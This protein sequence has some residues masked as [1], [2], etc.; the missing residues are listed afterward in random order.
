MKLTLHTPKKHIEFD[1]RFELI[2]SENFFSTVMY[3][4]KSLPYFNINNHVCNSLMNYVIINTT[5]FDC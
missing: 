5:S 2:V 4:S 1:F 3:N